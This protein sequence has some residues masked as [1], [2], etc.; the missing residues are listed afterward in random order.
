MF[1]KVIKYAQDYFD[2]NSLQNV[3]DD[4]DDLKKQLNNSQ[5]KDKFEKSVKEIE[6]LMT[7]KENLKKARLIILNMQEIVETADSNFHKTMTPTI[8]KLIN[9]SYNKLDLHIKNWEDISEIKNLIEK[10][11]DAELDRLEDSFRGYIKRSID[12]KWNLENIWETK[13]V[14]NFFD[15][16]TIEYLELTWAEKMPNTNLEYLNIDY[17]QLKQIIKKLKKEHSIKIKDKVS[18]KIKDTWEWQEEII[19][20]DIYSEIEQEKKLPIQ[21]AKPIPK[22]KKSS[23]I[24]ETKKE[25]ISEVKKSEKLNDKDFKIF[26]EKW[27]ENFII[28]KII[29][30]ETIN[31][32]QKI[33]KFK[34][35]NLN[36]TQISTKILPLIIKES[37]LKIKSK[38]GK[39]A[40]WLAQ[41]TAIAQ[42]E[43]NESLDLKLN[44]IN[45]FDN[46]KIA[47]LYYFLVLPNM[48][49]KHT[50]NI[51]FSAEEKDNFIKF[52]YN[53]W[54]TKTNKL[55]K[56]Y[57]DA[58]K[59]KT[60]K[61]DSFIKFLLQRNWL[62]GNFEQAD[63]KEYGVKYRN[64]YYKNIKE[65]YRE[66]IDYVE[67]INALEIENFEQKWKNSYEKIAFNWNLYE[68]LAKNNIEPTTDNI[69]IIKYF[70]KN[71][72]N[73]FRKTWKL[74]LFAKWNKIYSEEK[75]ANNLKDSY[76]IDFLDKN[77]I[78]NILTKNNFENN[79]K[80]RKILRDYNN[81]LWNNLKY[82]KIIY[83]P[84]KWIHKKRLEEN[85]KIHIVKKWDTFYEISNKL[86]F[87]IKDKDKI[88]DYN[89]YLWN[90]IKL[91]KIEIGTLIFFP[92]RRPIFFPWNI[93]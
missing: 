58:K 45:P 21:K 4:L 61:W 78:W 81:E 39:D 24:V 38:S 31:E 33:D 11:I 7:R 20:S 53:L 26:K 87:S 5:N 70:N 91:E 41:I 32:L 65:S 42:K 50:K 63:S 23:K 71:L 52:A 43:V 77:N 83:L 15:D 80:N 36:K 10:I 69:N 76:K 62:S 19:L 12:I 85:F 60:I 88:S 75:L 67:I 44:R 49:E 14:E 3:K 25:K 55:I 8:K 54:P 93:A 37:H 74:Y 16:F 40:I 9:N 29:L 89:K 47:I 59:I 46:M 92:W 6:I 86:G 18:F 68:V 57:L 28:A 13:E 48:L 72:L 56:E 35:L 73:N 2:E 84:L 22:P 51:D 30:D 17:N 64:F 34:E 66:P 90:P 1:E 82:A 27:K 79:S